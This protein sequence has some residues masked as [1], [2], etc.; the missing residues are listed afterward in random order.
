MLE[1]KFGC[2]NSALAEQSSRGGVCGLG[3]QAAAAVARVGCKGVAGVFKGGRWES[4]R[5]RSGR[6]AGEITTGNR[7]L[8]VARA[9]RG[10]NGSRNGSA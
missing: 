10:G 6:K 5:A 2:Y 8:A 7:V 4:R 9:R 3:L 1:L